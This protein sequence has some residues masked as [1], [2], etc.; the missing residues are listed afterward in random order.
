MPLIVWTQ[1]S[2][3][4]LG[5]FYGE[6]SIDILLPINTA[7]SNVTFELISG[8]LPSGVFLQ[9]NRLIGAPF[10]IKN[11]L[12]YSFCIRAK[13]GTQFSDRT[14][15]MDL[16]EPNLPTFITNA[17]DLAVGLHQQFYVLDSTFVSYQ[18]EAFDLNASGENLKYFISSDDGDLPPGLTLSESGLIEGFVKPV[19]SVLPSSGTG[20]FDSSIYDQVGYDFGVVSTN[21]FDDYQYDVVTFDYNVPSQVPITLNANYQFRVTLTDGINTTQRIFRIFVVG[22]DAFRADSTESNGL[23][24]QF[25]A[26][27]TYIRQPFWITKSSLGIFRANNYITLPLVLYDK[28]DVTFRLE[29]TNQEVYAETIQI[30]QNDNIVGSNHVTITNVTGTPV[31]GQYFSFEF[32]L[33]NSPEKLYQISNVVNLGS[34]RYRLT[35]NSNLLIT[36]PNATAFYIGSLTKLPPGMRFDAQTG[37][38]VGMVPY[39]PSVSQLYK[40]TVTGTRYGTKDDTVYNSRTFSMFIIGDVNSTITWNTDSNL[41]ESP[42]NYISTLSINASSN[43]PNATVIYELVEG[44]LPTGLTLNPDGE[45]IGIPNQYFKVATNTLGLIT[46][47]G[48]D[49]L[50]DNNTT[51]VDRE[52]I[53]KIKAS[54]QYGYSAV[55]QEFK[56]LITTPNTVNYSNITTRPF[57]ESTQ[58]TAWKNF[59]NNTS[60]FNPE[61]IY[62]TNDPNFGVQSNLKMIIYAGIETKSAAAF[63][64]AMGLNHK[65]KRFQFGGIKKATAID[66]VTRKPVYEVIYV[67]MIDPMEPN[68]RHLPLELR[69]SQDAET[70]TVDNS[71]SIWDRSINSL[72]ALGPTSIRPDPRITIDSTGYQV[73]DVH[74]D[75]YFPSSI[76]NW[77]SRLKQVGL[78]ERNYL[79]LWMRSIPAGEKE[80][81]DYILAVP[82]CFCQ[83]GSADT[84]LL[85]IKFSGFDFK[86]LDYTVDRY[87]IDS[88]AGQDGDKY[89]VFRND[90][91]TV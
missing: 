22:N 62:R 11:K 76:T 31:I 61:S 55:Y 28:K 89:L 51:T 77:R 78:K 75:T 56:L 81:I 20:N 64:G 13:Q 58:R 68:G 23:A 49:T 38:V 54:D 7:I 34:G 32:Y 14:F 69:T 10:V 86:T 46:F 29:A 50:F 84:I 36:V 43:V 6:V 33:E 71:S 72:N 66:P 73:S 52:Y 90:R 79:P 5:T 59:I 9:G 48:G 21:G 60:I 17:G 87:I 42:A 57:L 67:Q 4:N 18:L 24:S 12:N 88:V 35:I 19:L 70:L 63:V 80:E 15:F 27:A 40:F 65:R 37:D 44:Q 41:G 83:V 82:L 26:D 47:D 25:T 91:I 39:Q 45:I 53:F 16:I 74:I 8:S 85:N 1:P 30:L 3:Y 2:G